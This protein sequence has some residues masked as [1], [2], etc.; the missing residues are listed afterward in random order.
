MLQT[1]PI[2][3]GLVKSCLH[4]A[5]LQAGL[6]SFEEYLDLALARVDALRWKGSEHVGDLRKGFEAAQEMIQVRLLPAL[7]SALN[8]ALH[9]TCDGLDN[10]HLCI[11]CSGSAV[12]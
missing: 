5:G 7:L 6:Q 2:S 11:N 10:C 3:A 1:A 4:H 9:D 12:L 8:M